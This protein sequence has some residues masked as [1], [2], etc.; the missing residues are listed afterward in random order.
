MHHLEATNILSPPLD[1]FPP[2]DDNHT[3]PQSH[4]RGILHPLPKTPRRKRSL[5][6]F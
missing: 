1:A 6:F 4:R 5:L 2:G 3:P